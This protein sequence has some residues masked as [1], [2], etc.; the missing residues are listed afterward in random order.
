MDVTDTVEDYLKGVFSLTSGGG[1]ASTSAIAEHLGVAASS[2][3]TMVSRLRSAGLVEQV[4]WGQVHL[5]AHGMT[6]ARGVV[7]RHRLL[8]TFLHQVL[9]LDW[10]E[11]HGE[12]EI[13]EHGISEH[14][15]DR[16]DEVLGHP[17]RDPHGDPIPAKSGPHSELDDGP[18]QAALPGT[19]FIV[20]RV[21]N[22]DRE[23][24][25]RLSGVGVTPGVTLNVLGPYS[26][27]AGT[28][29]EA[30]S[31]RRTLAADLVDALR[32]DVVGLSC[33]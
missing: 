9:Q 13:L 18:L 5:T 6:H 14:V 19:R 15:T 10:A 22:Q 2:A 29:V 32:G 3:S 27:R 8:E 23:V 20:R 17:A 16:I 4:T 12:A 7:R 11:I 31:C 26:P 25:R 33:G 1:T 28:E 24:L 21:V 30:G